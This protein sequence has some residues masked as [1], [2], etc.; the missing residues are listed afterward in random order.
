MPD[1]ATP[2]PRCALY[3]HDEQ[4]RQLL[5]EHLRST[6]SLIALVNDD[7]RYFDIRISLQ[8]AQNHLEQALNQFYYMRG[9][10]FDA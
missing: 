9:V 10:R 4:F 7:R 3:S 2:C 1:S 8:R 5:A 6:R